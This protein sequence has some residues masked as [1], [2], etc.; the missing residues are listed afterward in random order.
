ME[1][2]MLGIVNS[3]AVLIFCQLLHSSVMELPILLQVHAKIIFNLR[4]THL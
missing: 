1:E 4:S 2:L 3:I